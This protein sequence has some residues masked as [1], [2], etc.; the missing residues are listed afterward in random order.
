QKFMFLNK[1]FHLVF[2]FVFSFFLML[3]IRHSF[4]KRRYKKRL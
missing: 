2:Y 3:L 1:I 4:R